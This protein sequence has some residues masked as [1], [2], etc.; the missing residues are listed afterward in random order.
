MQPPT[1]VCICNE[2]LAF[3][4]QY[5]RYLLSVVRD[6]LKFGEVPIKLYLQKRSESESRAAAKSNTGSDEAAPTDMIE[7]MDDEFQSFELTDELDSLS[8]E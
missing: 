8:E 3:S 4:S 5:Q 2:P 1:I 7:P 6:H